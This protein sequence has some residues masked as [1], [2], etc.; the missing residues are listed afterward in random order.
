MTKRGNGEQKLGIHYAFICKNC[1]YEAIVSGG[2]DVG[3][4]C[5]TTTISCK[6][7]GELFDVITSEMP[8]EEPTSLSGEELVCPG[9]ASGD[10][11]DDED[12]DRSK[13]N[14][15]VRRWTSP[16]PCPKCGK[17]MTKGDVV[18]HWD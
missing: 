15:R 8:W 11:D 9:P 7:C 18:V 12:M 4:A 6:D 5:R 13:P 17:A 16:G 10:S 1:G 2:D 14:H 3:M